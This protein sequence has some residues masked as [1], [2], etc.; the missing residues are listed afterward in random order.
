MYITSLKAALAC[1][2]SMNVAIAYGA[3]D[4]DE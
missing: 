1:A 3:T 2:V 4:I